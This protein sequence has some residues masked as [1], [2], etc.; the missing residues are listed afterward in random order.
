MRVCEVRLRL[1]S[2][3][4]F[5]EFLNEQTNINFISM[6]AKRKEA[7]IAENI[8]YIYGRKDPDDVV[9]EMLTKVAKDIYDYFT[10]DKK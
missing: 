9:V 5:Y 6:K 10:K 3:N 4:I 8:V 2:Q 7:I 1:D